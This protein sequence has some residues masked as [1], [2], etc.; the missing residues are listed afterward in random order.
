MD[1]EY[2]ARMN[3]QETTMSIAIV[4]LMISL[5]AVGLLMY[6]SK[7]DSVFP[8]V[9]SMCPDF[10]TQTTAPGGAPM[11]SPPSELPPGYNTD[12]NECKIPFDLH[13]RSKIEKC[14]NRQLADR[15]GWTWDGI[16]NLGNPCDEVSL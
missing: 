11:C 8:P 9:P 1:L 2:I 13:N 6:H 5:A 4:V 10:W 14:A 12:L 15:C 3:F 16:T 7:Q